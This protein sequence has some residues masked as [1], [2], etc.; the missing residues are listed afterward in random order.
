MKKSTLQKRL[1]SA[2]RTIDE[3]QQDLSET[4]KGQ[5]RW[6]IEALDLR[7]KLEESQKR[8]KQLHVENDELIHT[9]EFAADTKSA[10]DRGRQEGVRSMSQRAQNDMMSMLNDMY[11]EMEKIAHKYTRDL[12]YDVFTA[13]VEAPQSAK[14]LPDTEFA[15]ILV[16]KAVKL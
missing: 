6:R 15:N 9:P 4:S 14:S 12:T 10:I 3:L 8:V 16:Q 7:A 1:D 11:A 2:N 13:N 5:Q